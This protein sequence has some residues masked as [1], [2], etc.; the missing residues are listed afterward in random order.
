MGR[1]KDGRGVVLARPKKRRGQWAKL[2]K[3]IDGAW[4]KA[5]ALMENGGST[6][7][8]I[9]LIRTYTYSIC[10]SYL[11]FLKMLSVVCS[12]FHLVAT[13]SHDPPCRPSSWQRTIIQQQAMRRKARLLNDKD[14]NAWVF[15][16]EGQRGQDRLVRH[17]R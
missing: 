12:H 8:A 2:S 14:E 15:P 17:Q 10:S 7:I 11:E 5:V 9:V 3:R 13:H 1:R 16:G 6:Y 4:D